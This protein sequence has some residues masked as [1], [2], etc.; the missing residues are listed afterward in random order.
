MWLAYIYMVS[1][2]NVVR[3]SLVS[4]TNGIL[5]YAG[6]IYYLVT[7]TDNRRLVYWE[8]LTGV[9]PRMV[10]FSLFSTEDNPKVEDKVSIEFD[11]GIKSD[12]CDPNILADINMLSYGFLN[13]DANMSGSVL[14]S[15]G[16][17]LPSMIRQDSFRGGIMARGNVEAA[18]PVI[19]EVDTT[20]GRNYY[21]EWLV[22]TPDGGN[23]SEEEYS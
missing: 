21:L 18:R 5:D 8:K 19:R 6:S 2:T 10:P 23:A 15:V 13:S 12:P 17:P 7:D 3:P 20:S 22:S 16:E 4:Q 1:K 9:F 14:N 11:Y